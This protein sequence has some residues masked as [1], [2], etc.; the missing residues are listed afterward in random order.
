M[1]IHA[2]TVCIVHGLFGEPASCSVFQQQKP[3][4][5]LT[6]SLIPVDFLVGGKANNTKKQKTT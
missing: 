1:I 5:F 2:N 4:S 3:A 6:L